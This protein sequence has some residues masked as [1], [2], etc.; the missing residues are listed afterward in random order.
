V[1][2]AIHVT[3]ESVHGGPIAR[4]RDGDVVRLDCT[5]GELSVLLDPAELAAREP[6]PPSHQDQR[7][8]GRELFGVLR[9]NVGRADR[10]AHVFGARPEAEAAEAAKRVAVVHEPSLTRRSAV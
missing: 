8:T 3:P 9:R 2:A 10:G 1:P 5:T 7:G 4:L 6:A